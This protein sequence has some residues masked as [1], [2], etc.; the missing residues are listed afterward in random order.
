MGGDGVKEDID[1]DTILRC[2]N[3]ACRVNTF[4]LCYWKNGDWV[5]E[6][7]SPNTPI[8]NNKCPSCGEVAIEV[9]A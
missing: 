5:Y 4:H 9:T 3:V 2:R 8:T 1:E 7:S 6:D